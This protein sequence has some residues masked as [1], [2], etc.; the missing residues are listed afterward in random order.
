MWKDMH[1]VWFSM[2]DGFLWPRISESQGGILRQVVR[3][4]SHMENYTKCILSHSLHLILGMLVML[5][6]LHKVKD[7]ENDV[8]WIYLITVTVLYMGA[9]QKYARTFR[10]MHVH[11]WEVPSG[12]AH[13][14]KVHFQYLETM[15]RETNFINTLM[16]PLTTIKYLWTTLK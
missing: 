5:N 7:N 1:F 15:D 9:S 8:R 6:T 4:P 10:Y 2:W 16:C 3:N 11:I 13:Q 12:T 14:S